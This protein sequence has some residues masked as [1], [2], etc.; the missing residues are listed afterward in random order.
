MGLVKEAAYLNNHALLSQAIWTKM[1]FSNYF[2]E[3]WSTNERLSVGKKRSGINP[4]DFQTCKALVP[5]LAA[6]L[7]TSEMNMA[8]QLVGREEWSGQETSVACITIFLSNL[9]RLNVFVLF[10]WFRIL[11]LFKIS[12]VIRSKI[13]D[14]SKGIPMGTGSLSYIIKVWESPF[15]ENV[16]FTERGGR[17]QT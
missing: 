7:W 14:T 16:L 12:I 15:Y 6:V 11:T 1:H 3:L 17:M 9:A 2:M 8:C 10:F 4:W 13:R 5:T